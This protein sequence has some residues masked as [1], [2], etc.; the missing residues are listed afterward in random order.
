D[1][2]GTILAKPDYGDLDYGIN[3]AGYVINRAVNDA[4]HEV[5]C[6][7]HTHSLASM[8]VASLYCGLLPLTQ[9]AMRFLKIGCHDYQ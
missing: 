7:I 5:D 1:L 4:R 6:V 9:T 3:K 2:D 8:A